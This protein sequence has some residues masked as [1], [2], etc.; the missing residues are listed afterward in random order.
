MG[1]HSR[2]GVH[3]RLL[4]GAATAATHVR[5]V[6]PA[7]SSNVRFLTPAC[8]PAAEKARAS[9]LCFSSKFAALALQFGVGVSLKCCGADFK[10]SSMVLKRACIDA[11]SQRLRQR[12]FAGSKTDERND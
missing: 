11:T 4:V 9:V 1:F 5:L 2:R 3:A 7:G 8:S 6:R 12:G 10:R